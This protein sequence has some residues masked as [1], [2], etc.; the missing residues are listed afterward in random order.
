M[1]EPEDH[2]AEQP[3]RAARP[4]PPPSIGRRLSHAF[5][6][7]R[8]RRLFILGGVAFVAIA[9]VASAQFRSA[10]PG[11]STL[12]APPQID[13]TPGGAHQANTPD[14]RQSVINADDQRAKA[15]EQSGR[16]ALAT[17][18]PEVVAPPPA[19]LPGPTQQLRPAA[20]AAAS[21]AAEEQRRTRMADAM[22]QQMQDALA[23]WKPAQAPQL[24]FSRA[25]AA[26][27]VAPVQAAAIAAPDT[28]APAVSTGAPAQEELIHA[29]DIFYGTTVTAER[30]SD[31]AGPIVAD[32]L[33]G[34]LQGAR[35]LGSV[36]AGR[37]SYVLTFN[38]MSFEGRRYDINAVAVDVETV[39][40][41]VRSD[42]D[43]R[44]PERILAV[45][46]DFL[47]AAGQ[48]FLR[49][50]TT[51]VATQ[52]GIVQET[53]PPTNRQAVQAGIGGAGQG[54]STEL[55]RQ[56]DNLNPVFEVSANYPIGILFMSP[57]YSQASPRR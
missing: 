19:S 2:A 35:I 32:I 4:L 40:T 45:G 11:R 31:P 42:I 17:I 12:A 37:E 3:D 48:V 54:L 14:Y 10:G 39:R 22:R 34:P 52:S 6:D 30:S 16:S 44:F 27:T 50:A 9:V 23:S 28:A 36:S 21:N 13:T 24:M 43:R 53:P 25:D 38:S 29:G 56:F 1:T 51:T 18:N 57:I 49:P 8:S 7:P 55:N 47:Q 41:G 46:A 5:S 33:S 26:P 15:A 20:A